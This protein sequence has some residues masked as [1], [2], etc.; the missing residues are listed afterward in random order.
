MFRT[1]K[2][3]LYRQSTIF[4]RARLD[5]CIKIITSL[6]RRVCSGVTQ[7]LKT[8]TSL[9][10]IGNPWAHRHVGTSWP[11]ITSI[12]IWRL[13]SQ[14]ETKQFNF[15]LHSPFSFLWTSLPP[16]TTSRT[17]ESLLIYLVCIINCL[18][19]LHVSSVSFPPIEGYKSTT[20]TA[21]SRS[22]SQ[23]FSRFS[24]YVWLI[25]PWSN[26]LQGKDFTFDFNH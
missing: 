24:K 19:K 4:C 5:W 10:S 6:Y 18:S 20:S 21:V 8:E 14:T 22:E 7:W 16:F 25:D 23:P 1:A 26:S 3:K 12:I 13:I 17:F 11:F 9:A 2:R 15:R